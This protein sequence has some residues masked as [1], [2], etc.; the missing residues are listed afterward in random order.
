VCVR[1]PAAARQPGSPPNHPPTLIAPRGELALAEAEG[2]RVRRPLSS[3]LEKDEGLLS[4]LPP[5]VDTVI[6]IVVTIATPPLSWWTP[7]LT[8]CT[9]CWAAAGTRGRV[10]TF[11]PSVRPPP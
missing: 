1:A 11:C 3:C 4:P 7:A 2:V 6:V 10:S 9:G 5:L 8:P